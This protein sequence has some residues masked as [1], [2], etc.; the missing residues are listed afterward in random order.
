MTKQQLERLVQHLVMAVEARA[1]AEKKTVW[2]DYYDETNYSDAGMAEKIRLVNAAFDRISEPLGTI[3]DFGAN[4]GRFSRE[5]AKRAKH[6]VAFDF[7]E[8]VINRLYDSAGQ[9]S[10]AESVL[11]LV[12]DLENPSPGL[13]WAHRER[14]SLTARGGADACLALALIHHLAIGNNIPLHA[15][16]DFFAEMTRY[17]IIEFVPKP[18]SQVRR[19]LANRADIFADYHA[20]GFERAFR[21]RFEVVDKWQ[22]GDSVRTLYLM[23]R[24]AGN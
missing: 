8:T 22:I 21:R 7:D 10:D 1:P 6:V 15:V 16:A 18:D 4:T 13:G 20:E 23:K 24:K 2:T 14:D 17:L 12:M 3:H 11:P 19:L 9:G 5:A